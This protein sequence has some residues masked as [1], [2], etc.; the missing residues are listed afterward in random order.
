[1]GF[2]TLNS[3]KCTL[4]TDPVEAAKKLFLGGSEA[5]EKFVSYLAK[6]MDRKDLVLNAPSRS[7]R[8]SE[9]RLVEALNRAEEIGRDKLN[10]AVSEYCTTHWLYRQTGVEWEK[11]VP[12][13]LVCAKRDGRT[14]DNIACTDLQ[15]PIVAAVWRHLGEREITWTRI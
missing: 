15:V 5:G 7:A 9:I 2:I 11:G 3:L 14:V 6:V 1:M 10:E 12:I 13:Y 4:E 8:T